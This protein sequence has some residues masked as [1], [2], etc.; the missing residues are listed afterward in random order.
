MSWHQV[1]ERLSMMLH[2]VQDKGVITERFPRANCPDILRITGNFTVFAID[3]RLSME[4]HCVN[5]IVMVE[6]QFNGGDD[7]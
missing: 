7:L 1:H 3:D 4:I 6:F 2:T 5:D